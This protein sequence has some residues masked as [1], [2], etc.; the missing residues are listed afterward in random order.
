MHFQYTILENYTKVDVVSVFLSIIGANPKHNFFFQADSSLIFCL[1]MAWKV[2]VL[3]GLLAAGFFSKGH[4]HVDAQAAH[5]HDF[6]A[7][8]RSHSKPN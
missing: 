7:S 3:H 4:L 1:I 2:H 5:F 6:T 8:V